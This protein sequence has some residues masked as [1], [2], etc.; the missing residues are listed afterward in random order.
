MESIVCLF[1]ISTLFVNLQGELSNQG[2][3][4]HPMEEMLEKMKEVDKVGRRRSRATQSSEDMP[5][6]DNTLN[7]NVTAELGSTVYLSCRVTNLKNMTVGW[8][9]MKDKHVLTYGIYSFAHDQRFQIRHR[10]DPD[11]WKLLIKHVM[12]KDEGPYRCQ[13]SNGTEVLSQNFNLLVAVPTAR[14]IGAGEIRIKQGSAISLVCVIENILT[15]PG[16]VRW[17]HNDEMIKYE[18]EESQM[19]EVVTDHRGKKALVKLFIP[20][21]DP[22]HSGNYTC[23]TWSATSD[24]VHVFVSTDGDNIVGVKQAV[25]QAAPNTKPFMLLLLLAYFLS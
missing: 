18:E 20:S 25:T 21:A 3:Q 12:K 10:E 16:V 24:P 4:E 2:S 15:P 11:D 14:I 9:R 7:T 8:I 6:F 13:V 19:V 17:Y 22:I 23:K 5:V 1:I